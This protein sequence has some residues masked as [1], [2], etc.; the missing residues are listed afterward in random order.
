MKNP[1]VLAFFAIASLAS[2][3]GLEGFAVRS[4]MTL[5]FGLFAFQVLLNDLLESYLIK[6]LKSKYFNFLIAPGTVVHEASHALVA[7]ATGCDITK[8]SFFNP[9]QRNG[10]LGFVEYMQPVDRFQSMRSLVIGLAPFFGCGIFLIALLN[11]LALEHPGMQQIGPDLVNVGDVGAIASTVMLLLTTLYQQL[12]YVNLADPAMILI[13]YLEFSFALGSAPSPQDISDSFNTML[14]YKLEALSMVLF[15]I[16]AILLIEYGA[17][18]SDYGNIVSAH[19]ILA[20]NWMILLLLISSAMLLIAIPLTLLITETAEIKGLYKALPA[21]LFV[22]IYLGAR[23]FLDVPVETILIASVFA[24][25]LSLFVLR[26]S[27]YFLKE[28]TTNF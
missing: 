19:A 14:K 27:E 21:A 5:L 2:W 6:K 4:Y 25:V 16:S 10:V 28:R 7:K 18:L 17:A 11:Y 3:F 23:Q 26:H 24:Y 9:S 15:V 8:V 12:L 13:L 20:F 22:A 1:Y